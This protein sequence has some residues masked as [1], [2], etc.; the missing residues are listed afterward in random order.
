MPL[1]ACVT[2][3]AWLDSSIS[4]QWAALS[5][6]PGG[7]G[8]LLGWEGRAVLVH[9]WRCLGVVVSVVG[10][11]GFHASPRSCEDRNEVAQEAL[12]VF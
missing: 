9:S 2:S 5:D 1:A 7:G 10:C 8:S 3:I 11:L 4:D 6:R 12:T